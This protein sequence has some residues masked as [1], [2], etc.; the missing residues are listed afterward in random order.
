MIKASIKY[1]EFK[2]RL[3][4]TTSRGTLHSK[5]VYYIVLYEDSNPFESGIGECSLF[6]G[7]SMDDTEGFVEKLKEIV[8]LINQGWYN[9]KTPV[10][11]F[12]S[13]NFALEIAIKDLESKGSKIL[14]PSEFTEG[15]M[16][17]RINGLIWMGSKNDIIRQIDE[18][19]NEGFTCVKMKIGALDFDE[20][21]EILASL[22]KRYKKEDLEIRLDANGA[23][24]ADEA[25]EYLYRLSDLS[26]HSVEQPILPSQLEEMAALC[27]TTPIPVALD[28]E[29]IGKYPI[30]NKR[31]LLKMIK[32]QYIVLKPGLLGGLK[33]C[34]EWIQVAEDSN[35]GWWITSALE[36]NIGLNAIAQ[37]TF[38][39]KNKMAQGLGTG[40]LFENNIDSPLAVAGEKLYYFPRKKWDLSLFTSK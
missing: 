39:L 3:P 31:Q 38:T 29:L 18:K 14:F 36:T 40:T 30:E 7:L 27:E 1:R 11:G 10:P 9:L 26:V 2:F 16:P 5:S 21:Y 34:E 33:S 4:A 19:L 22:R 23:F 17:V 13:I 12:P 24:P 15:K 32:P 6:P 37:W 28:E 35:I 20:E 25:L 8:D